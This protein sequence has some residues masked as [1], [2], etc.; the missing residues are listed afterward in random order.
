MWVTSIQVILLINIERTIF[1]SP[2]FCSKK[3]MGKHIKPEIVCK[4]PVDVNQTIA[5]LQEEQEQLIETYNTLKDENE[6]VKTAISELNEQEDVQTAD[7]LDMD[8]RVLMLE[9]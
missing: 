4:A 5:D 7:L 1:N 2:C 8:M 3:E 9:E 6:A